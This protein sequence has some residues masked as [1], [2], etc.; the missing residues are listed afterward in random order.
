LGGPA[1][2]S[3]AVGAS[4]EQAAGLVRRGLEAVG[5]RIGG[6]TGPFEDGSLV[7]DAAG[8]SDCR[9]QIRLTPLSG[10]THMAV[11]YGAGCS[12]D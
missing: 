12:F 9:V 5:Y 10:T 4:A 6:V 3:F 2:G 1:S 11:M 8:A 7:L